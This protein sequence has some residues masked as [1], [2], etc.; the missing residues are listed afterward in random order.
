MMLK[1]YVDFKLLP[2][3]TAEKELLKEVAGTD[4]RV[5]ATKLETFAVA[6]LWGAEKRRSDRKKQCETLL[7]NFGAARL[8]PSQ[9][10]WP[11]ILRE[12]HILI[13]VTP[14]SGAVAPAAAGPT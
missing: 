11:P 3:A 6:Y 14:A 2:A 4:A 9:W 8:D 7:A 12:L 5:K 13:G 10:I 1:A